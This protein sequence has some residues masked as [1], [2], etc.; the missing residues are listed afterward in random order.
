MGDLAADALG[1]TLAR[2]L[3]GEPDQLDQAGNVSIQRSGPLR[4]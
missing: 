1:Q 3:A 4:S 2:F